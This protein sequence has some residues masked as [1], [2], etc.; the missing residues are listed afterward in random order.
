MQSHSQKATVEARA[1]RVI[2]TITIT[3]PIINL[4]ITITNIITLT[5]TNIITLTLTITL[6]ITIEARALASVAKLTEASHRSASA[7]C[8]RMGLTGF[9]VPLKGSIGFP[10]RAPFGG[11]G[12]GLSELCFGG[13]TEGGKEGLG[14]RVGF[15]VYNLG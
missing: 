13:G 12:F 4:F 6:T 11:L 8:R 5:I 9:R 1:G 10:L 2:V 7:C 3:F 15:R 14:C